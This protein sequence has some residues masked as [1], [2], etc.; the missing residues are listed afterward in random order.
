M[1]RV[2]VRLPYIKGR[3]GSHWMM[4]VDERMHSKD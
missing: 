4:G 3:H 2:S 1:L